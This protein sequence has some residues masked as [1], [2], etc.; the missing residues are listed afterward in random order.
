MLAADQLALFRHLHGWD[1]R[2]AAPGQSL[3][4]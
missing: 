1:L 4:R 3:P 2:L